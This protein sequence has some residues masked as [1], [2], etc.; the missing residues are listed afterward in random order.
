VPECGGGEPGSRE[1]HPSGP[2]RVRE[3]S[4]LADA[5]KPARQ[6]VLDEAA[7]KLHGGERQRAT[8]VD[9][10][11]VLVGEGHVVPIDGEEPVIAD[12]YTMGV[13]A[14]IPE[15]GVAPPK[16]GLALEASRSTECPLYDLL[17]WCTGPPSTA[18]FGFLELTVAGIGQ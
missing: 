14:E 17:R 3:E 15:D 7:Q 6:D 18:D 5:Y 10:C 9:M 11:V 8:S 4:R 16:A 2:A 1:G 12:R 13:A